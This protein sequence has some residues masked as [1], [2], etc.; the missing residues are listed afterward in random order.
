MVIQGDGRA[1]A[2]APGGC[3]RSVGGTGGEAIRLPATPLNLLEVA[4][5]PG[6]NRS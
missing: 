5:E 3:T 6:A 4:R 1:L 2:R